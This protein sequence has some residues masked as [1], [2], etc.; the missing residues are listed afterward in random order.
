MNNKL[1]PPKATSKAFVIIKLSQQPAN[2]RE[3][4][5]RAPDTV[6]V[7][8]LLADIICDDET[9]TAGHNCWPHLSGPTLR[10]LHT[11]IVF[12]AYL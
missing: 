6:G 1:V 2:T 9:H 12:L 11:R 3:E 8:P 4:P 7:T 5:L 10:I